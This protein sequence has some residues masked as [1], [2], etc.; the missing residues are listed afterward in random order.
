MVPPDMISTCQKRSTTSLL[1]V[2]TNEYIVVVADSNGTIDS[3]SLSN[4]CGLSSICVIPSGT[5][6]IMDGNV[7][8]GA[9]IVRGTVEWNDTTQKNISSFL[10]AGYVAVESQGIWRMNLQ[11]KYGWIYIKNN[12]AVHPN[13]RER[14]FGGI[15]L[16]SGDNPIVDISG[17]ELTRTWSLLSETLDEGATKIKLI[18]NPFLMGWRIG[19]RISVAPTQHGSGGFVEEFRIT[20][21]E[22]NGRIVLNKAANSKFDAEFVPSIQ[23]GQPALKSAEVINLDR[24]IVITG[25]DFTHIPC[26][27]SLPEAVAGE[28]TSVLGC[29][30]ASFRSTCTIG[31][32][33]IQ[34]NGGLA[35]I[36]NTR[37]EKCGQRG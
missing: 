2:P 22:G 29:R 9:L 27:P 34:M 35:R 8:V 36:Q 37:I 31:L 6:L 23:G 28:Q 3:A 26:D 13:L 20:D 30:C 5:R 12:G 10:C 11:E 21:I 14:A 18:H 17:R 32:H 4:Q 33:Q 24:N 19:D 15:A 25:D 16:N 1:S 7:N